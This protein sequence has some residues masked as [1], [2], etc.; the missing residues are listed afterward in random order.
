[1]FG[2]YLKLMDYLKTKAAA[3]DQLTRVE[4]HQLN[5]C[6]NR[7][8]LADSALDLIHEIADAEKCGK[9]D[10]WQDLVDALA[11]RKNN[12]EKFKIGY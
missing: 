10:S 9:C 11:M 1:M 5:I 2:W 3:S 8:D 12:Q 6:I 7:Y 4:I